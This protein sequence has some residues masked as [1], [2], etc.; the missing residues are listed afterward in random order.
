MAVRKL[1]VASSSPS[2]KRYGLFEHVIKAL[3][4]GAF[5]ASDTEV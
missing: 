3:R 4:W 5:F 1:A 2:A